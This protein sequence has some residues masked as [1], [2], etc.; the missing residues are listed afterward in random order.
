M[1]LPIEVDRRKE[2]TLGHDALELGNLLASVFHG[3]VLLRSLED[4]RQLRRHW[5]ASRVVRAVSGKHLKVSGHRIGPSATRRQEGITLTLHE[6]PVGCV[7][8]CSH[9]HL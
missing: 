7:G 1:D 8:Y 6:E 4:L 5:R 9:G 3:V 2:R